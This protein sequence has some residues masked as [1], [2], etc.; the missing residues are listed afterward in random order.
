MAIVMQG[1]QGINRRL[2]ITQMK[3]GWVRLVSAL[4]A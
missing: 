3:S 4:S 2:Q 1:D